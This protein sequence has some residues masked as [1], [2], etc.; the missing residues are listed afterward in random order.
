MKGSELLDK[1]ELVDP[2]YVE[3]AD[4]APRK[5]RH[6]WMPWIAAAACLCAAAGLLL[7][8]KGQQRPDASLA[9]PTT[10]QQPSARSAAPSS[11]APS[12]AEPT[13]E[14]VSLHFNDV[15]PTPEVDAVRRYIAGYFTR[16][17][18]QEELRDV[19]PLLSDVAL[20]GFAGFLP[21][22]TLLDV[23][24]TVAA[25]AAAQPFSVLFSTEPI[26]TCYEPEGEVSTVNGVDFT[27]YRCAAEPVRLEAY[28]VL[29]GYH[30]FLCCE[31]ASGAEADFARLL[32][33]LSRCAQDVS[34][35]SRLPSGPVPEYFD[36]TLTLSEARADALFGA[37]LPS[38]PPVGFA[39]ESIRRFKDQK[40]DMLSALW[41]RGYDE[42][43]WKVYRLDDETQA[44]LTTAVQTETY[45]LSLYPIPRA[46][47]VPEALRAVVDCPVFPAQELSMDVVMAR[48]YRI[49]DAGDGDGWR[50]H[51]AVLYDDIVVE[52]T[53]KGV[54]PAWL[55]AQLTALSGK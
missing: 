49:E 41:C 34:A 43:R 21:D 47:S 26:L 9:V 25:P 22:G 39:P 46:E 37:Y 12:T 3:A 42:L 35:L 10:A 13:A 44:R 20:W 36:R 18:T 45:D 53:A 16:D 2:A 15:D 6:K 7:L 32:G 38:D 28:A 30:V 48:A 50:M 14:T 31:D 24:I 27:V 52:V 11:A 51:F 29:G 55:W 54:D 19:L 5:A 8:P 40:D 1:M 4:A 23:G 17:L 33:T